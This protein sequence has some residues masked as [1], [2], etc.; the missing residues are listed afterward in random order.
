M[1]TEQAKPVRPVMVRLLC[2]KHYGQRL[3]GQSH[4]C[5]KCP[6]I[7]KDD[8]RLASYVAMINAG[9]PLNA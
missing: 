4:N 5:L 9:T 3:P 2:G 1:N 6:V 7:A 8:P